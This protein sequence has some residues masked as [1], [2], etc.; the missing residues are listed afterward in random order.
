MRVINGKSAGYNSNTITF[1][2]PKN[3]LYAAFAWDFCRLL[4]CYLCNREKAN[5][6]RE[7]F[8]LLPCQQLN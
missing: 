2:F 7:G 5:I 3:I 1:C 8:K 6:E 4:M